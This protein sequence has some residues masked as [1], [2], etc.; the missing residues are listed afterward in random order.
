M[1]WLQWKNLSIN[2]NNIYF[3]N[4]NK[5]Q[6]NEY[7]INF[8]GISSFIN[9]LN[10][11]KYYRN[12]QKKI[13]CCYLKFDFQEFNNKLNILSYKKNNNIDIDKKE[14]IEN[15][16]KLNNIDNN[17]KQLLFL[18]E[19]KNQN[20]LINKYNKNPNKNIEIININ[21]SNFFESCYK[22]K[23][24]CL[25]LLYTPKSILTNINVLDFLYKCYLINCIPIFIT[26]TSIDNIIT[27]NL[28][29]HIKLPF[30]SLKSFDELINGFNSNNE[31]NIN[32]NF[33]YIN[34]IC[35]QDYNLD[36]LIYKKIYINEVVKTEN[37][38]EI[39]NNELIENTNIKSYF[40]SQ[41]YNTIKYDDI[42]IDTTKSTNSLINIIYYLMKYINK[43][44]KPR[45]FI[46]N[47]ISS[48]EF[49]NLFHIIKQN[50]NINIP[51]FEMNDIYL[52]DKNF[53]FIHNNNLNKQINYIFDNNNKSIRTRVLNILFSESIK[54]STSNIISNIKNKVNS[55]H[56]VGLHLYHNERYTKNKL[57]KYIFLN[58]IYYILAI[59]KLIKNHLDNF[60]K[61]INTQQIELPKIHFLIFSID[62]DISVSTRIFN[63]IKNGYKSKIS[64][65]FS[66][67]IQH[68]QI[69]NTNINFMKDMLL[70]NSCDSIITSNSL[71]SLLTIITSNSN[72]IYYPKKWLQNENNN[73][74]LINNIIEYN[75]KAISI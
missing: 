54:T 66:H 73:D 36:Y 5:P 15:N 7:E 24:I 6:K 1:K 11:I 3:S 13:N 4:N 20:I 49:L 18:K 23:F 71:F 75:S 51:F 31:S 32:I 14:N 27:N 37:N 68:N 29:K 70:L 60:I 57:N 46:D 67:I 74:I 53:N 8:Q 34:D 48:N 61:N 59:D 44:Y 9:N 22:Y 30:I 43:T 35:K 10:L 64:I 56:I 65:D 55:N 72:N 28:G 52:N 45:F 21:Y 41:K 58:E 16:S 25:D 2:E 26:K 42:Y 38:N 17:V 39:L 40:N 12:E 50:L 62:N 63:T 69:T 19:S 33:N 47:S